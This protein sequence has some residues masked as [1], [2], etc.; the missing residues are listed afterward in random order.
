[1]DQGSTLDFLPT[2]ASL[3]GVELPE[4]LVLDGYDL[5]PT[6]T[7]K[8][9][10]P[11]DRMYYYRGEELYAVRKGAFKAHFITQPAYG[12]GARKEHDPPLLFHLHED[13]SEQYNV[14]DDH[15][16]MVRQLKEMAEAFENSFTPPPSQL[17]IPLEK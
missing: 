2:F 13:P 10:S 5:T 12:G 6:L 17:E 4:D 11:R 9:R 1:M 3:S 15:P 16:E 7:E 8:K 14:A